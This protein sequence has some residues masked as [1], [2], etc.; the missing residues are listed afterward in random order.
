MKE[1]Q[2]LAVVIMVCSSSHILVLGLSVIWKWRGRAKI[3]GS[4]SIYSVFM[5]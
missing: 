5:P 1:I 3:K 4:L 2:L